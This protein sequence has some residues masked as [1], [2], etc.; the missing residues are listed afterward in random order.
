MIDYKILVLDLELTCWDSAPPEGESTE[1][2]EI[3][4]CIY[5]S[6]SNDISKPRSIYITPTRSTISKFCTELT[7]ITKRQ[8]Y[9]SGTTLEHSFNILK[10]KYGSKT[11]TVCT[12]GSDMTFI[13]KECQVRNLEYPFSDSHI[14]LSKLYLYMKDEKVSL[15]KAMEN[16]GLDFEG[17]QHSGSVDAYNT[18]RVLKDLLKNRK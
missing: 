16:L 8:V 13:R 6:L 2:I 3:G 12:W 7:G 14:D 15:T 1:I 9:R 17:R 11:H 4:L 18:A 10:D 5:N